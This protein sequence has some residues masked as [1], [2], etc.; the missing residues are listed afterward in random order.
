MLDKIIDII[1]AICESKWIQNP[2]VTAVFV[3]G[4]LLAIYF[5][6]LEGTKFDIFNGSL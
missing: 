3:I 1:S 4:V 2:V 5:L 6:I